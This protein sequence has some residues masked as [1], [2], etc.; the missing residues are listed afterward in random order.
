MRALAYTNG[1]AGVNPRGGLLEGTG[2]IRSLLTVVLLSAFLLVPATAQLGPASQAAGAAPR[3][4]VGVTTEALTPTVPSCQFDVGDIVVRAGIGA[5]VPAR[6][7][8]VGGYADGPAAGT[9]ITITTSPAGI[10][11]IDPGGESCQ[12]PS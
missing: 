12:L 4:P 10:V 3:P 1:D 11:T 2:V 5:A 7:E 6:G 9:E 8:A